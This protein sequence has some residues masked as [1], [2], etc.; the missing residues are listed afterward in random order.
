MPYFEKFYIICKTEAVSDGGVWGVLP[1][2]AEKWGG[3]G[4][5]FF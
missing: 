4:G 1:T 5:V 3:V 2:L